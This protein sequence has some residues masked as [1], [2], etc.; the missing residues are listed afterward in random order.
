MALAAA[1]GTAEEVCERAIELRRAGRS[2]NTLLNKTEWSE[3]SP[4]LYI[5]AA[6]ANHSAVAALLAAGADVDAATGSVNYYCWREH[7]PDANRVD[8]GCEGRTALHAAADVGAI[9]VARLL[10]SEGADVH[11]VDV[12][13]Q[14]PLHRAAF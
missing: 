9:D 7:S 10:L 5:A 4:A 12:E 13:N 3:G 6:H 1:S 8:C 14:T 2:V 11:E